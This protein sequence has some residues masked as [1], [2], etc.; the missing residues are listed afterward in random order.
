MSS[1]GPVTAD[2][3]R[4]T[5][6]GLELLDYCDATETTLVAADSWLTSDGRTLGLDLHRQ[7]FLEA[8][9]AAAEFWEAA[10][11][12]VPRAGDWFPRVEAH[13]NGRLL[14]RLRSA[15]ERTRSVVLATH[16]GEDPRTQPEVKGPDL[17]AMRR[18]RATAQKEGAD[19]TIITTPEGYVVEGA[20]SAIAWWRGAILCTPPAEF[21]RID[22]VTARSL[23]TLATALGVDTHEE[24][25]TPAELDGTEI[26]ALNALQGA[27]IVTRWIDGP[28]TAEL[29][30]R[31]ATWRTR[32]DRLA[33]PL[34]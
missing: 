21:A 9:P 26:W 7:R 32:L 28:E 6:S 4:W 16:R 8:V 30:G 13:D 15:P 29:P 19:E 14:F 3:L 11:A 34:P 33:R 5:G 2:I 17:D 22:S 31:L 12:A 27:R 24:A 1:P 18:L 23:V 20:Y 25:V 10:I